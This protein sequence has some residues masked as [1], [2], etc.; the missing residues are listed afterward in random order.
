MAPTSL[1]L[2]VGGAGPAGLAAA[3]HAQ[4]EGLAYVLLERTDHLADTI[5]C[6]QKRKLVMAEPA[7]V[8]QAGELPFT[9]GA[10]EEVLD[11]WQ[12]RRYGGCRRR[13]RRYRQRA[14]RGENG[15]SCEACH[16]AAG[17]WRDRHFEEGWTYGKSLRAGMTDLR[18]PVKRGEVCLT[19]HLGDAERR[20]DHRLIAAVIRASSSSSTTPPAP[21]RVTGRSEKPATASGP[22][23]RVRR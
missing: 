2:V 22:G 10:R 21:C 1:D 11:A 16:G 3:A 9:I 18:N 19:C 17:G 7:L 5:F 13:H 15:I 20:V 12:R 23:P 4:E 14:G 6:Y 8:P